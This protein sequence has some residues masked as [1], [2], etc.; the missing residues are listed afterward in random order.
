[1]SALSFYTVYQPIY[2]NNGIFAY[3]ALLRGKYPP[4]HL[5]RMAKSKNMQ[6]YLDLYAAQLA[7]RNYKQNELLAINMLPSTIQ[8]VEINRLKSLLSDKQIIIEIT[9]Q[10]EIFLS[11]NI[12]QKVQELKALGIKI[13]L[14]DFGKGYHNLLSIEYLEPEYIK[15]DSS[16]I[17]ILSSPTVQKMI[18]SMVG[19]TYGLNIRLIAEGVETKEQK[20]ILQGL[21]ICYLQGYYLGKPGVVA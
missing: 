19:L 7:V 2:H 18:Q 8:Q 9:E 20:E 14:D 11:D 13:A 5:F 4:D 1:V 16:L 15:L 17:K 10:D 12:R 6:T 3:E 21:G